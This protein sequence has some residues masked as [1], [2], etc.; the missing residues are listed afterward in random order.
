MLDK[1]EQL[2]RNETAILVGVD[3]PGHQPGECEENLRELEQLADTAGLKVVGRVIQERQRINATYFIGAGKVNSLRETAEMTEAQVIVF[4]DDLTPAQIRNLEKALDLKIIDRSTLILDIFAKHARTREA[5][6]QV[7]LAQLQYLLPRLTR[8]WT[9]LSRQVGG[10][11]TRGPG[12]TQLETDR[13]LVRKRIEKLR[14]DLEQI[15]RQRTTRSRNRS[16]FFRAA[17][18]GY[19]NVG[20]STMMNLLADSDVLV[21]NQL[22]ATLDSTHRK[23]SLQDGHEMILSDTV[24]FI[25]KLPHHLVASFKSTLDVV[26]DADLLIHVVDLSHR[27]FQEQMQTVTEVLE[28]LDSHEKPILLV[29]NK[30]DQVQEMGV[31]GNLSRK[32]PDAVFLSALRSIG[33][34]VLKQKL[35]GFLEKEFNTYHMQFSSMDQKV[36]NFIH[37][38]ARVISQKYVESQVEITFRCSLHVL[39]QIKRFQFQKQAILNGRTV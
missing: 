18:I 27:Q 19:T 15:D 29:F 30:I 35:I 38:R 37:T 13:R 5:K 26:R 16:Q 21:E 28:S 24:G 32:F 8:H 7:E 12:E 34:D 23:V 22:F 36:L 14:K 10:I 2:L 33:V 9:H 31:I 3:L 1:K 17:L 6:T 11:G 39:E 20:K 4:D 25:R